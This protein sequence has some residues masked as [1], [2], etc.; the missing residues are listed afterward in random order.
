MAATFDR[1]SGSALER[2]IFN[3]RPAVIIACAVVTLVLALAAGFKLTLN[4]SFERM[5][6]RRLHPPPE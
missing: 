1:N 3:H 5:L 6:P 2:L 4:A